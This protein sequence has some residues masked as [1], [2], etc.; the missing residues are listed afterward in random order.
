MIQPNEETIVLTEEDHDKM[1]FT[2]RMRYMQV[3]IDKMNENLVH[4]KKVHKRWGIADRTIKTSQVALVFGLSIALIIVNS[5]KE[6]NQDTLKI[7]DAC[8]GSL[9]AF[10]TITFEATLIA[11]TGKNLADFQQ[12]IKQLELIKNRAYIY[13]EKARNDNVITPKEIAHFNSIVSVKNDLIPDVKEEH[14]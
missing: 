3:E 5:V 12:R 10:F 2:E 7:A 1:F 14:V 11:F 9:I 8:I 6:V 4:L 13:Y